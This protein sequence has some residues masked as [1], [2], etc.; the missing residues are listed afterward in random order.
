MPSAAMSVVI[1]LK[2]ICK[3][4]FEA[5]IEFDLKNGVYITFYKFKWV[6][7]YFFIQMFGL[8]RINCTFAKFI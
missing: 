1:L 3:P 2:Y 5:E 4:I 7:Q 6:N 8:L